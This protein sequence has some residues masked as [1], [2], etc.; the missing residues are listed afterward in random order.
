MFLLVERE[1]RQQATS[2][3]VTIQSTFMNLL[4][5]SKKYWNVEEIKHLVNFDIFKKCLR[6]WS[7]L[8]MYNKDIIS[9]YQQRTHSSMQHHG[10]LF[11]NHSQTVWNREHTSYQWTHQLWCR[12]STPMISWSRCSDLSQAVSGPG[13]LSSVVKSWQHSALQPQQ[14]SSYSAVSLNYPVI[15]TTKCKG[16]SPYLHY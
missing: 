7:S 5:E 12:V 16:I 3:L 13:L 9:G 14:Y 1:W 11:N 10:R 8:I 6:T 2:L 15:I 4:L